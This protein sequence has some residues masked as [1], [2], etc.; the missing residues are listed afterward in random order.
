MKVTTPIYKVLTSDLKSCMAPR[1]QE[2]SCSELTV[3]YKVNEWT[4]PNFKETGLFVFT[5][6]FRVQKFLLN[7]KNRMDEYGWTIWRG[8]G[9][10][11]RKKERII[12]LGKKFTLEKVLSIFRSALGAFGFK[13]RP[14]W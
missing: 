8:E 5:N 6:L 13:K 4:F 7:N 2:L 9:L 14:F 3:Q 12:R 1:F 11:V 10:N